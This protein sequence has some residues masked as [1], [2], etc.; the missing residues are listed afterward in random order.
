MV[1]AKK[2]LINS[3]FASETEE[4]FVMKEKFENAEIEVIRLEENDVIVTSGGNYP[5]DN[6]GEGDEYDD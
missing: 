1:K 4:E 6:I 3:S 2:T 5:G